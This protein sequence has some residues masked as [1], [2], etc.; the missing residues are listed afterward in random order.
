MPATHVMVP[1]G[2]NTYIQI[3]TSTG[4]TLEFM[5]AFNDQPGKTV[6][7]ATDIQPIGSAYPIEIATPYAQASGTI[8]LTVWKTW[9]DDGWVSAFMYQ[10]GT[11]FGD[12]NPWSGY[13]SAHGQ[14]IGKPCDLRE[15]LDAQRQLSNNIVVKKVEKASDGNDYRVVK[16]EGAVITDIAPDGNV[17]QDTMTSNCTI[18]IKYT[19]IVTTTL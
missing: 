10:N 17:K 14:A 13:A 16:Y 2:G 8:T 9:K 4:I 1:G 7:Q 6:G 12:E 5:S 11:D 15:V 3:G 18:T 19:H